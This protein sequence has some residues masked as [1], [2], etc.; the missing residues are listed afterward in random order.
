VV[1]SRR[2]DGNITMESWIPAVEIALFQLFSCWQLL[3][4]SLFL[5]FIQRK[6]CHHSD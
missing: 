1:P 5:D 2:K 3:L 4:L 6:H